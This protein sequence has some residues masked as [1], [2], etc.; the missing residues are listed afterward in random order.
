M[1]CLVW[2]CVPACSRLSLPMTVSQYLGWVLAISQY[3]KFADSTE[4]KKSL[5]TYIS[6]YILC[7]LL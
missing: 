5:R 2:F 6:H 7:A 4:I 3:M 1:V